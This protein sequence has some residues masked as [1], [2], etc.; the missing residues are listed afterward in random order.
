[1]SDFNA[2]DQSLDIARLMANG[3]TLRGNLAFRHILHDFNPSNGLSQE[4]IQQILMQYECDDSEIAKIKQSL[5]E[6]VE[7]VGTLR[8]IIDEASKP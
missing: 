5:A 3:W 7:V 4:R 6:F 2:L 8:Q 1:M